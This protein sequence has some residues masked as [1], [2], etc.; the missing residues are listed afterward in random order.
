[1][2]DQI[3]LKFLSDKF[4]VLMVFLLQETG[5]PT[6]LSEIADD[7]AQTAIN[8]HPTSTNLDELVEAAAKWI[9]Q[10]LGMQ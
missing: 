2:K 6:T 7:A 3:K 4:N 9:R 1:M 8:E 10:Q 5:N